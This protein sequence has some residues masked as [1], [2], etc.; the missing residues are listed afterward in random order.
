MEPSLFYLVE[1]T[2]ENTFMLVLHWWCVRDGVVGN[3]PLTIQGLD[4][5]DIITR[6]PVIVMVSQRPLVVWLHDRRL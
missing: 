5:L 1:N 6:E 4:P 3:G 2:V